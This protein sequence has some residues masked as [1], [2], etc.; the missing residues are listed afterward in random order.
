[1][2]SAIGLKQ[3]GEQLETQR[4]GDV[5]S[6]LNAQEKLRGKETPAQKRAAEL[7]GKK[8]F[9]E[10]NAGLRVPSTSTTRLFRKPDGNIGE[11]DVGTTV[12]TGWEPISASS[13]LSERERSLIDRDVQKAEDQIG[14]DGINSPSSLGSMNFTNKYGGRPYFYMQIETENRFLPGTSTE[15]LAIPLPLDR[16]GRQTTSTDI[17][18]TA[19]SQ[20]KSEEEVLRQIGAIK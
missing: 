12:P 5:L 10:F 4:V 7:R 2:A 19:E 18:E 13:D 8:E 15:G 16:S 3:R 9:A 1:M 14:I 6:F 11:L 20:G 17:V